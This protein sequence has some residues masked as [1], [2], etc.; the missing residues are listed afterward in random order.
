ME[1]QRAIGQVMW[2]SANDT[3][4]V[5][6]PVDIWFA[7]GDDFTFGWLKTPP[8][9]QWAYAI[10]SEKSADEDNN[11]SK[12]VGKVPSMSRL[13]GRLASETHTPDGF[14]TTVL[15]KGG[16]ASVWNGHS[17]V[18]KEQSSGSSKGFISDS[19][20]KVRD[21]S[22]ILT[23]VP[24]VGSVA[25]AISPIATA[26][27][28]MTRMLKL[29]KPTDE[30]VAES[31]KEESVQ[32]MAT[33]KGVATIR[34]LALDPENRVVSGPQ[35]FNSDR[36]EMD[37]SV[38]KNTPGLV[39]IIPLTS[40]LSPL[41]VIKS[42]AVAPSW[43]YWEPGDVVPPGSLRADYRITPTAM[44]A[45]T[46]R[47][48]RGGMKVHV[49]ATA[50]S[51]VTARLRF[52]W[53]PDAA[54]LPPDVSDGG[55]DV[56]SKI[57]DINGDSSISFTIPYLNNKLYL[58]NV[59]YHTLLQAGYF[60][61][62]TNDECCNGV[63]TLAV[64]NPVSSGDTL[65]NATIYLNVWVSAAEDMV[66]H[67]PTFPP[68]G[69]TAQSADDTVTPVTE[70]QQITSFDENEGEEITDHNTV[71]RIL[72]GVNPYPDQG[73]HEVLS[74]AYTIDYAWTAAQAIDATVF[75][76]DAPRD[77]I[78]MF[79]NI[80]EKLNRFQYFR[81]GL[82][83]E[84]R[85]NGT[86]FHS[87]KII[88]SYLPRWK[89]AIGSS[90]YGPFTDAY[91]ASTSPHVL[92]SPNTNQTVGFVIPYIGPD[93]YINL[94]HVDPVADGGQIGYLRGIVL[95]PLLSSSLATAPTVYVSMTVSFVNPEVAAPSVHV[96]T[97]L[98]G[99]KNRK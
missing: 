25:S 48:W 22:A 90:N 53:S 99:E 19:I 69:M 97:S 50:S 42:W 80:K 78:Q 77:M 13:L 57:W 26:L 9:V 61:E 58:P 34:K 60:H 81:A 72:K 41:A 24:Y 43:S 40:A 31:F 49:Q 62:A 21:I 46:H 63:L 68:P 32:E 88:V 30:K 95:N 7:I 28:P 37:Y 91:G 23:P 5:G 74:R 35:I 85:V 38:I 51:F 79:D 87:G 1:E 56:I 71:A 6:Q 92:I 33:A 94:A 3:G 54:H 84:F 66:F 64:V 55:G 59:P 83:V 14:P 65:T 45:M 36:S 16:N 20:R 29:G 47:Y 76:F 39:D 12:H 8:F 70:Q 86:R 93:P 18:S 11:N 44:L 2:Q 75:S 52:I 82:K 4:I 15:P 89:P 98:D 10:A 67:S 17:G 73:L 96:I 27:E